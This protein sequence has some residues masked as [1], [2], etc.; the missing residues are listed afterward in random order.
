VAGQKLTSLH[1]LSEE[2]QAAVM[3]VVGPSRLIKRGNDIVSEGAEPKNSTVLLSGAACRYRVFSTGKRHI[4]SLQ[5]PGDMVD[6]YS[7]VM[8]RM[9]HS[10][11]TLSDCVVAPI[12]HEDI[13]A[14]SKKFPNLAYAF[15]RDTMVDASI[16]YTWSMGQGRKTVEQLAHMLCEVYMR[17]NAVG[18]AKEGAPLTYSL[19]QQDLADALGLSLVHTNKTEALLKKEGLVVR[20]ASRLTILNWTGLKQ[21]AKFDPQYLHF[22]EQKL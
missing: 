19:T 18:L 13:E 21:V 6:L 7:Y 11:G 1:T 9:D 16:S 17:L 8:K 3:A 4:L 22:K 20:T 14:L 5:C 15:W 10:I 12:P 2:E